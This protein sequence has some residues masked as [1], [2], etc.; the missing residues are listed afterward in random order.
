M[1]HPRNKNQNQAN[2]EESRP[3]AAT[4]ALRRTLQPL[5]PLER[6]DR[7]ADGYDIFPSFAIAEGVI[8][9]GHDALAERLRECNR[10]VIDGYA[11]V[12]WERF[13]EEL[14]RTFRQRGIRVN[15]V[16]TES[17]LKA[18]EDIDQ[19]LTPFLGGDDPVFGRIYA[20]ELLDFFD[21]DRLERLKPT[22]NGLNIVYG[23]GAALAGWQGPLVYLEVPKNEIQYRSRAGGIRNLG[24]SAPLSPRQQYKR[25][26][27]VDWVVFNKHKKALLPRIS[28]LVDEQRTRDITWI[29]GRELADALKQLSTNVFRARP[30]FEAGAWGGTWIKKHIKGLPAEEVNYAWSFEMITPENGLVLESSGKMLEVSFD[31]L[32]Y[33]DR[34]AVLGKA[35]RRFEDSFPIR[36]DFLDTFGGGNLSVQCHPRTDYIK[37]QFGEPFTQDETYYILDAAPDAEVY[38]G[39][40]EDIVPEIFRAA[41]LKSAAEGTE[42]N[43]SDFLQTFPAKK[44]DLFLIPNGTVHCSGVNNLVLE[45]SSTPYIYTFKMYD[46][47]RMDLD[48]NPRPLNIERAFE[49]LDFSRKGTR[50]Q[51]ELLSKPRILDQGSDW[52]LWELPTHPVH[53]YRIQRLEFGSEQT[54]RTAGQAHLL[55]LVEGGPVLVCTPG[56]EQR[57]WYAETF[58]IPAAA[59]WYRLINQG[60]T[61]AK[62]IRAFVKDEYC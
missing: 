34:I 31:L 27:F 49:N 48:G 44:H 4:D 1:P 18:P 7:S 2:A 11:G 17:A 26:Y 6:R 8:H 13:R 62:V 15:W 12:Y 36:F 55:S 57:V 47:Q 50:V 42:L 35:A 25:F 14:D 59:G 41:L 20:G 33:Y 46:W 37:E 60:K 3:A 21:R 22:S 45:I 28:I 30:W 56:R 61:E 40:R 52:R 54:L 9:S 43:V 38:L 16:S 29:T 58:V 10:V 32:M 19:L 39:F 24:Q 53:F 51:Q 5:L 23:P